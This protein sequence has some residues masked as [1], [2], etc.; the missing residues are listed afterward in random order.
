M[1][2]AKPRLM[3]PVLTLKAAR[4]YHFHSKLRNCGNLQKSWLRRLA[5]GLGSMDFLR[6]NCSSGRK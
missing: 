2:L 1:L 3:K 5:V 6:A 4:T